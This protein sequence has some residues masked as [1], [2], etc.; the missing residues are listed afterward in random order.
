MEL[1]HV[2]DETIVQVESAFNQTRMELKLGISIWKTYKS[3]SFNQTRMELKQGGGKNIIG[4]K[5]L[6]IRP[7]W[8]WNIGGLGEIAKRIGF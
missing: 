7:E 6:L 3:F 5:F 8:N 2:A 1:K 4:Q